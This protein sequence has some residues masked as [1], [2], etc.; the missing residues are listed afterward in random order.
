VSAAAAVA[1]PTTD[2]MATLATMA[3]TTEPAPAA[4][5]KMAVPWY[6]TVISLPT[7]V[8]TLIPKKKRPPQ[9]QPP[10]LIGVV[11]MVN[12]QDG[13]V[14]IDAV[15][16]SASHG[17]LLVCINAQKETAN[18]RMSNLKNPPFLIADI[19]SGTPAPGDRVFIP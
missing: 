11:K 4:V 14:L 18:L 1:T 15:T 16:Q 12:A 7:K 13:F 6:M 5:Q 10:R 19:A 17:D 9:A 8:F 2:A 3:S